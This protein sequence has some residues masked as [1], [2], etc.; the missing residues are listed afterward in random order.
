[1][2]G[3]P[4]VS[5]YDNVGLVGRRY[6]FACAGVK[7]CLCDVG[8]SRSAARE[9]T[10]KNEKGKGNEC[11]RRKIERELAPNNIKTKKE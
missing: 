2:V 9:L 1:M 11:V 6:C 3:K 7:I 5:G 8:L 10:V 4:W